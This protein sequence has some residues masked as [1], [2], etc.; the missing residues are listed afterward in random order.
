M[1][2]KYS[3][4]AVQRKM[5]PTI[6][7]A[8]SPNAGKSTIFNYITG[9]KQHT[10]N[11]TGKTVENAYGYYSLDDKQ[12]IMV[13]L[14]GTYSLMPRSNDE[15]AARDFICFGK[16]DVI[17]VVVDATMLER[18]LSLALQIIEVTNRVVLCVNLIDEANRKGIFRRFPKLRRK[19]FLRFATQK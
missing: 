15:E 11:W 10:G 2:Q 7:L 17:V 9:L 18:Q 3:C 14:P 6:A 8:G 12:Y 1:K 5:Q 19:H 16:P 4:K 13:D